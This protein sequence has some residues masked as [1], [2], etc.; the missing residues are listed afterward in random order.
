MGPKEIIIQTA[1]EIIGQEGIH[2]ITTREVAKR[3]N[4]N[5]AALNYHFGTKD[6]LI[7]QAMDVFIGRLGGTY[8]LLYDEGVEPKERLL[9]FLKRFAE[10]S[11][12][13]P[14]VTKS[15]VGQMM[16][17]DTANPVLLQS[18]R[19][20]V[21]SFTDILQ[22][23]TGI[24]EEQT[25]LRLGLQMMAAVIYPVLLSKQLPDLYEMN[26]SNQ[27]ERE[28]YIE[29]LFNQYVKGTIDN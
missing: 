17:M 5:S 10:I 16:W 6:N 4:V 26:Y 24:Q 11:V 29:Q 8:S 28:A 21:K 19:K 20:G 1:L 18:Q 12:M 22:Q 25:L 23:V 14:G 27:T 7:R 2:K 9:A 3:A 15:L 13:F